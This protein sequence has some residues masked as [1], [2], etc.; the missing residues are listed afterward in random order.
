MLGL[1]ASTSQTTPYPVY[2]PAA[3]ARPPVRPPNGACHPLRPSIR[4]GAVGSYS[5]IARLAGTSTAW[6]TAIMKLADLPVPG[7]EEVLLKQ[8]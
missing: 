3:R 8:C 5:E 2:G 6:I 7:Q 1:A 4:E